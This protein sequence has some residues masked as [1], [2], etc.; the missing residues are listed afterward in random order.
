[1]DSERIVKNGRTYAE[2]LYFE[3]YEVAGDVFDDVLEWLTAAV[4][5]LIENW[6]TVLRVALSLLLMLI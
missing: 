3:L 1:M 4:N 2:Q 5:W 6:E